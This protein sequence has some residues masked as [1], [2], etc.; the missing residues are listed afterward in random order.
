MKLTPK[1]IFF[2][3]LLLLS[4]G[5]LWAAHYATTPGQH[6]MQE[7]RKKGAGHPVLL[8]FVHPKCTCSKATIGELAKLRPSLRDVEVRVIFNQYDK[9]EDWVKGELWQQASKIKNI[10]LLPDIGGKLTADYGVKT[11][12]HSFLFDESGKQIFSGGLTIA[13]GHEGASAGAEFLKNWN[14][15]KRQTSFFERVF[16]CEQFGGS[17]ES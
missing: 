12:G 5:L 15:Q 14:K 13:R 2:A 3:W 1:K 17:F 9:N 8:V 4:A 11:S 6:T 7:L 10:T 16:G